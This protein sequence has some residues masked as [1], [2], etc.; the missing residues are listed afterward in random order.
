[1]KRN[2][3]PGHWTWAQWLGVQ[4]TKHQAITSIPGTE[5]SLFILSSSPGTYAPY[6]QLV[7]IVTCVVSWMQFV[8]KVSSVQSTDYRFPNLYT[9]NH[10]YYRL[11][12]NHETLVLLFYMYILRLQYMY[13][14]EFWGE[15]SHG[16]PPS[17]SNPALGSFFCTILL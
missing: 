14:W 4:C 9:L 2:F 5:V 8:Q 6:E 10:A 3:R 1:M 16:P 7:V 11:Y 17:V 12:E 15:E 13:K